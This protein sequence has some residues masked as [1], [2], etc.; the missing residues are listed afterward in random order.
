MAT[1]TPSSLQHEAY[2]LV[3]NRAPMSYYTFAWSHEP[4]A[5]WRHSQTPSPPYLEE[6]IDDAIDINVRGRMFTTLRS[7]EADPEADPVPVMD[8]LHDC[9]K[10]G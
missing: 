4:K 7:K 5:H 6:A 1:I 8:L 9:Y 10:S 3:A 2:K